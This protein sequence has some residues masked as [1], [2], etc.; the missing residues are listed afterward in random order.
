MHKLAQSLLQWEWVLL[1]LLLFPVALLPWGYTTAFLAVVPLLW[2]L[3]KAITGRFLTP[4]PYDLAVLALVLAIGLSLTVTFDWA[5]SGPKIAGILLGI[6]FL[7]ATAGS[8]RH[9]GSLWPIVGVVLLAGVLM[10]IVGFIGSQWLPPFAFLN[11]ARA[12][13]PFAGGIPGAVGGVV[14]PNEL[15]GV[16]SWV[17]PLALACVLTGMQ[18]PARTRL[19]ILATL[20]PVMAFVG[21]LLVATSSRG[22]MLAA[23]LGLLLVIAFFVQSRWRLVL[24]IGVLVGLGALVAYTASRVDQNIVGDAVGMSGRLEIWSRALLA[25]GDFPL[26]GVGVNGFRRVIDVLYPLYSIPADIDLGHA[27]NQMLQAAL[28]LG[29]PGLTAYLAIWAISARLLW[30]SY[31]HL[32]QRHA[33]NHPYYGLVAGLAGSL[34][35]GWVFGIFD[36]IAL[37]AR[38][39]FIWWLLLGLTAGVHYAVVY[40]GESLRRHRRRAAAAQSVAP[41]NLA[42]LPD[43][44]DSR[45][46]RPQSLP[47]PS[48]P[49]D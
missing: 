11:G 2:L 15:A 28:D 25:I 42:V 37:G 39:G 36:A 8:G 5:T 12:W 1:L 22:G 23:G 18:R 35:A 21:F 20:L 47:A 26:T 4:T 29:L 43:G 17:L 32:R 33:A 30:S 16:L 14:N 27:H 45:G 13:L 48:Q 6:A 31:R 7:Y 24:G 3:R 9:G 49:T 34:L 40:S 44:R 41:A 10:A 38:P 19:V 46:S